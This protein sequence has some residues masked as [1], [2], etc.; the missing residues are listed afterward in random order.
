MRPM[1]D[2]HDA[3]R[4]SAAGRRVALLSALLLL[5]AGGPARAR[6]Q[7]EQTL[8]LYNSANSD[9]LLVR[10][11]YVAARPGV[12]EFDLSD[13]DLSDG[14][15][16]RDAYVSR[17]RDPLRAF[18]GADDGALAEQI[19]AIATTRGLPARIAGAS[20]FNIAST[21]A[22]LESELSLLWQDLEA[23]GEGS[24]AT[25]AASFVDN[26]YHRRTGEAIESFDR[27]GIRVERSFSLVLDAA[28]EIQSLT[29]GDIYL[30]CRLD[31][32]PTPDG[33]GALD[34]VGA[35]LALSAAPLLQAC[36]AQALLDEHACPT[37]QLD[38]DGAPPIIPTIDDFD[39]AA[40]N[41][42]ALG[43]ATMQDETFAFIRPADLDPARDVL[44]LGTYG[45]NHDLP[46]GCGANPP[47]VGAYLDE[48]AGR[49]H[50]AAAFVSI[51]SFNGDSLVD[52]DGRGGQG[53]ALD[54]I[55]LGGAFTVATVAE[56]F[57]IGVADLGPLVAAL[58]TEG[59]TFAEAAYVSIPALSWQTTPIGD[60]LAQVRVQRPGDPDIDA[61]GRVA[62]PDLSRLLAAWG[63]D[64]CAADLD[65]SGVVGAPDLSRLLASW[66]T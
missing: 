18:L 59:M 62:A 25:R 65:A 6:L 39:E 21:F 33:S 44:A 28:W 32:P 4:R 16:A 27:S 48:Y 40:S 54:F 8:L 38:D 20:E 42:G 56:P 30:V 64:D 10:D 3:T 52:G 45:E 1:T 26:P 50:P 53:Q 36:R 41:L 49:L 14:Q 34:N 15:I 24:L 66:G 55:G 47:G 37:D 29:P 23:P 61:D 13:P 2:K 60:P 46:S 43:V 35:L 11:L 63:T 58:Y 17:V 31:A 12:V 5:I 7:P 19:V 9:S 57:T 51:E 22:S